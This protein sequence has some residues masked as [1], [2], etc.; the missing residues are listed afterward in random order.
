MLFFTGVTG[1]LDQMIGHLFYHGV[2]PAEI[3][4]MRWRELVYWAG[5]VETINEEKRKAIENR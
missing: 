1:P 4:G 5:W 2:S 3:K